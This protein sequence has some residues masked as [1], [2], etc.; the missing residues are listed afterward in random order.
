MNGEKRAYEEGRNRGIEECSEYVSKREF[1]QQIGS[2]SYPP[3]R[4][5]LVILGKELLHL[6]RENDK[7]I[8][9]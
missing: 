4:L 2:K 6:R 8:C 5:F 1:Y 9:S 3:S 7:S